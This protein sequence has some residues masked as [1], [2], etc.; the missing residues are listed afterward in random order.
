[1]RR[2]WSLF[3]RLARPSRKAGWTLAAAS[4]CALLIGALSAVGAYGLGIDT[5]AG[6]TRRAHPM[7]GAGSLSPR[8]SLHALSR[9]DFPARPGRPGTGLPNH[10]DA[11]GL[12]G[13]D[14]IDY[15]GYGQGRNDRI[16]WTRDPLGSD[17]TVVK[18]TLKDGDVA[19]HWGGP[20]AEVYRKESDQGEGA[21][22]WY[23]WSWLLADGQ[24]GARFKIPSVRGLGFQLWNGGPPPICVDFTGGRQRL[25]V[26]Q[27]PALTGP[28]VESVP[29][30]RYNLGSRQ[31]FLLH[32]TFSS[33]RRGTVAFWHSIG[34]P[35][36]ASAP[37]TIRRTGVTTRYA[38]RNGYPKLGLYRPDTETDAATFPWA[39]YV[40]GYRRAATKR[41]AL[42]KW[43]LSRVP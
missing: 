27:V 11:A 41:E 13:F 20:R 24:R 26:R 10:D 25:E 37:P 12:S 39:Y 38:A 31:Y 9:I 18:F 28:G 29:F 4:G 21:E 30:A 34:T 35:P 16:T 1:M 8:P 43:A 17:S 6:K 7:P 3:G 22:A 5:R 40:Y 23:T 2:D 33:R 42:A 36:S 14:A 15:D 19:T 32:V